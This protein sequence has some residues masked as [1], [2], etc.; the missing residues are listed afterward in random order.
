MGTLFDVIFE[1]F[2]TVGVSGAAAG[3]L[4]EASRGRFVK[5]LDS[6]GLHF[7]SILGLFG[8]RLAQGKQCS[9]LYGSHIFIVL[10]CGNR[11]ILPVRLWYQLFDTLFDDL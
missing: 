1:D 11:C 4:E 10:L 9:R 6:F 8:G 5:F 3:D 2:D 7:G